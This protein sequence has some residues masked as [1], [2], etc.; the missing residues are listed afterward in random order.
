[1]LLKGHTV[2]GA[3]RGQL[4]GQYRKGHL[5]AAARQIANPKHFVCDHRQSAR[6]LTLQA[7]D[8]FAQLRD[9]VTSDKSP[10]AVVEL[11]DDGHLAAEVTQ[12]YFITVSILEGEIGSE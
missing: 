11:Q 10:P 1:M 4:V 2:C 7:F 9:F 8:I 5:A 12:A 3:H 6:P